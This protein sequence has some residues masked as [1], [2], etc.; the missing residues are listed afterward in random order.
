MTLFVQRHNRTFEISDAYVMA[1]SFCLF[2][3]FGRILKQ[4]IRR[5]ILKEQ[6]ELQ[7]KKQPTRKFNFN[8]RREKSKIKVNFPNPD[9]GDDFPIEFNS[10]RAFA[11]AILGCIAD[12]SSMLVRDPDM[13]KFIF[14]MVKSY[15]QNE[16]IV[17]TPK[18][19]RFLAWKYL[20]ETRNRHLILRVGDLIVATNHK[21]KLYARV[22]ATAVIAI[23]TAFTK[24]LIGGVLATIIAYHVSEYCIYQCDAY[25]E[26]LQITSA[27]TINNQD[28]SIIML[29]ED[30]DI[31][32]LNQPEASGQ[33][34]VSNNPEKVEI[35]TP[36]KTETS[37]IL[38][39]D[40][41]VESKTTRKYSKSRKKARVINLSDIKKVDPLMS[42]YKEDEV[43]LIEQKECPLT[44]TNINN[45][46]FE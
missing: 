24:V 44:Q 6:K 17:L 3:V 45:M 30:R 9:G 39:E 32:V 20:M 46:M 4:F 21:A 12:D 8:K 19:L 35:H 40:G 38:R 16:A 2:Y 29:K 5:Q 41:Q 10:N 7:K 28:Q 14:E 25:F 18:L 1:F 37:I 26:P 23:F 15:I 27:S 31:V 34:I 33:V 13:K 36:T 22:G 11:D 42:I 43:P